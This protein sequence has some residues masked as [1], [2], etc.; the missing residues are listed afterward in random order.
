M[1]YHETVVQNERKKPF[2]KGIKKRKDKQIIISGKGT[3][4][5]SNAS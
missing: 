5:S 2:C 1:V 3:Y 4:C